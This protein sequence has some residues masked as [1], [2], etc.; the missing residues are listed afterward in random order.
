MFDTV[1]RY[2]KVAEH[3]FT[4]ELEESSP[5]WSE[6]GNYSPFITERGPVVFALSAGLSDEWKRTDR[7]SYVPE[8]VDR[9]EPGEP[10]IDLYSC[11]DGWIAEM[12]PDSTMAP[13]V[14]LRM[15]ADFTY[16]EVLFDRMEFGRYAIDNAAMLMFAFRTAGM[17]TL[18]MHSSVVMKDGRAY[19][20]L[21]KSGTGKSTQS[22][23]WLENI[24]GT[25]LLNDDNPVVR[26]MDDG[27]VRVFG[28]PWSG[29]TPCYRNL[30]ADL[31]AMVRI[32]RCSENRITRLTNIESYVLVSESCSG[33]RSI[34][35]MADGLY[36]STS[37]IV[38]RWP[39]FVLDCR[40]D[41]DAAKVCSE[42]V[43]NSYPSDYNFD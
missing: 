30:S 9:T 16:G 29:K 27:S 19:M 7:S 38:L 43:C 35:E 10:R 1:K 21:A 34:E 4:I 37:F 40:P 36:E 32:R 22:R 12:A 33:Y 3:C 6:L 15:C 13:V 39:C 41:A 11:P 24:P 31:G 18:E 14:S 23:M 42:T 5:L 2:Y 28:T 25:E 20:F 26:V 17:K 8:Y